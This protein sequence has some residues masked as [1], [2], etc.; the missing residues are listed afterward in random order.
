[1]QTTATTGPLHHPGRR[2]AQLSTQRPFNK[3]VVAGWHRCAEF[4]TFPMSL[5]ISKDGGTERHRHRLTF[6]KGSGRKLRSLFDQGDA[7]SMSD[8]D[9]LARITA[10]FRD[11]LDDDDLSLARATTAA[12][13]PGWDSLAHVRLILAVQKAFKVKFSAAQVTRLRNV[14]DL[15]D[16]A[17][18]KAG[19]AG[20]A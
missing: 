6:E 10:V 20:V 4:I 5:P 2:R 3:R 9:T 8:G 7:N 14:G 19:A 17:D 15:V 11:V 12:V 18:E 13:V 16:L 1:M